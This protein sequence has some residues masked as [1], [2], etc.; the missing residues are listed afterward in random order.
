[1]TKASFFN[2]RFAADAWRFASDSSASVAIEYAVAFV[3]IAVAVAAGVSIFGGAV[4]DVY[5]GAVST[6]GS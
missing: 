3:V 5:D 2:T 1:M 4:G 6:F